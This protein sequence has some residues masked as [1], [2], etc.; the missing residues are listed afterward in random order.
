MLLFVGCFINPDPL[1]IDEECKAYCLFNEGTYWVYEDSVTN[2]RDSVVV[3]SNPV[4]IWSRT[5]DHEGYEMKLHTYTQ[6]DTLENF[7][8]VMP[9][10]IDWSSEYD[11][12]FTCAYYSVPYVMGTNPHSN[13]FYYD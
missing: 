9:K 10:Y 3:V 5:K 12:S 2:Q 6:T 8:I 13:V 4:E 11:S 1:K 7:L